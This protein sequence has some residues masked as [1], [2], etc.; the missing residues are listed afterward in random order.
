[1]HVILSIAARGEVGLSNDFLG[2]T[3]ADTDK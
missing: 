2:A 1:M 3:I